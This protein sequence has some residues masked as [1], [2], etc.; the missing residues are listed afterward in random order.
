MNSCTLQAGSLAGIDFRTNKKNKLYFGPD[1]IFA[2]NL[3][4]NSD[5]DRNESNTYDK[6]NSHFTRGIGPSI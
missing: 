5:L 4:D 1:Q 6:P 2:L 3:I